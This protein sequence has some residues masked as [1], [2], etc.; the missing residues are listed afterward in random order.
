MNKAQIGFERL[1]NIIQNDKRVASGNAINQVVK[2]DVI[3]VLKNYF[4]LLENTAEVEIDVI[5]QNDMNI[6]FAI[7]ASRVK[8]FFASEI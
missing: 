1:S 2:A 8:D 5:G 6:Y 7:K 3:N 4:D